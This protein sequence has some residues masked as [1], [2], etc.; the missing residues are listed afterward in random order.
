[1]PITLV[2][3]S[4][5]FVGLGLIATLLARPPPAEA[6]RLGGFAK[7]QYK[8]FSTKRDGTPKGERW[9]KGK[10]IGKGLLAK[11]KGGKQAPGSG[12]D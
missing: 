9:R 1:M 4:A 12:A 7:E 6:Q 10:G 3:L 8:N 2:R 11:G 5:I